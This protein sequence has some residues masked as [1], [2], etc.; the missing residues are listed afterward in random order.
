MTGSILGTINPVASTVTFLFRSGFQV[1][2]S[3]AGRG[4]PAWQHPD[5][6]QHRH[7]GGG[8]HDLE[9]FAARL[10]D[11]EQILPQEVNSVIATAIATDTH[12]LTTVRVESSNSRPTS[13]ATVS[14]PRPTM[15]WP[16]DTPLIGPVRM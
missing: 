15:Y 5:E 14:I 4:R 7:E 11:A 9:R 10:V 6:H 12:D 8:D 16:A 3:F 1:G 13:R 2:I